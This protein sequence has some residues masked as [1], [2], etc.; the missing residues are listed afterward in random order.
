V[1]VITRWGDVEWGVVVGGFLNRIAQPNRRLE[2]AIR[3]A[4]HCIKWSQSVSRLKTILDRNSIY[5]PKCL[6]I[7]I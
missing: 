7:S 2:C 4:A 5:K 6:F 3:G 1:Y